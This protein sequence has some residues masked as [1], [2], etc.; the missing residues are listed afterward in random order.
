MIPVVPWLQGLLL[1]ILVFL[2]AAHVNA[3]ECKSRIS[4]KPYTT[5]SDVFF[6]LDENQNVEHLYG[7]CAITCGFAQSDCAAR[8]EQW[9]FTYDPECDRPTGCSG[10]QRSKCP[11]R[12][13][14]AKFA[15]ARARGDA[16]KTNNCPDW[17]ESKADRPSMCF[18]KG[19]ADNDGIAIDAPDKMS[20]AECEA[21][22]GSNSC[23][24]AAAKANEACSQK[25]S[26][27]GFEKRDEESTKQLCQR[28]KAEGNGNAEASGSAAGKCREAIT[29]CN[30]SCSDKRCQSLVS[31]IQE[32]AQGSRE[33]YRQSD[34]GK[35]CDKL[36]SAD[37]PPAAPATPPG[38]AQPP[39]QQ[40]Y[41]GQ[42]GAPPPTARPANNPTANGGGGGSGGGMGGGG[43]L[44]GMPGFG[45]G[46]QDN[47]QAN[48]N[49]DYLQRNS[50]ASSYKP[51]S[52]FEQKPAEEGSS[53]FNVPDTQ[54]GGVGRSSGFAGAGPP[55][56]NIDKIP[57]RGGGGGGV[58]NNSGGQ[59]PG[60]GDSG[61]AKLGGGGRPGSPG[62]PG[63]STDIMRGFQSGGGAT[64]AAAA[65]K[66]EEGGWQ[67]YGRGPSGEKA[68]KVDLRQY[69][70]GQSRDPGMKIGG[71]KPLAADIHSKSVNHWG[72]ITNRMLERCRL[73]L[74]YDCR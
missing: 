18:C 14:E 35:E 33:L 13:P 60:G 45:D 23:E 10:F 52:G 49:E 30:E 68:K 51:E 42:S 62:S 57:G 12:Q 9:C 41:Q 48:N 17:M 26:L 40:P 53:D 70:P 59:I 27:A 29:K 72:R 28:V 16:A 64:T 4:Q 31:K 73:G 67:G 37:K 32:L 36:L 8:A 15:L 50:A 58:A 20:A 3:L 5:P 74:L 56:P 66:A 47:T 69:L 25:P 46:A 22:Y 44:G 43:G 38:G 19:G 54:A 11:N 1:Y 24:P 65:A 61:G 2:S 39:G 71:F 55:N 34:W 7:L 6:S 63:Y 21:R